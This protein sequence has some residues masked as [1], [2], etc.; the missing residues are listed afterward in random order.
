MN[1]V[2]FRL[3]MVQAK[4]FRK[5][6]SPRPACEDSQSSTR[7]SNAAEAT[8]KRHSDDEEEGENE[9]GNES[10][11]ANTSGHVSEVGL[12]RC[13]DIHL[14]RGAVSVLIGGD[15]FQE[16]ENVTQ[17]EL[18]KKMEKLLKQQN[19]YRDKVFNVTHKLRATNFGQDR[20]R[21]R[22]WV[23]PHLGGIYVEG[24]E[25]AEP[26]EMTWE[27]VEEK[28]EEG[29][30]K[31][32]AETRAEKE[33][34][35]KMEVEIKDEKVNGME[36]N[37]EEMVSAEEEK[38][39]EVNGCVD[40][41]V[42]GDELPVKQ[43]EGEV[44]D[45]DKMILEKL[46]N[47]IKE[48]EGDT[49]VNG[50]PEAI[51]PKKVQSAELVAKEAEFTTES[52]LKGAEH[53]VNGLSE[54]VKGMIKDEEVVK[55]EKGLVN[56]TAAKE[57]MEIKKEVVDAEEQKLRESKARFKDFLGETI[58]KAMTQNNK[59]DLTGSA[60]RSIDSILKSDPKKSDSVPASS[61]ASFFDAFISPSL[62]SST[63]VSSEQMLKNLADQVS[64]KT[65]S[66]SSSSHTTWFSLVPRTPC[67]KPQP[68]PPPV[69]DLDAP[70]S[71]SYSPMN[72]FPVLP[73][74]ALNRD[75]NCATPMSEIS[76]YIM[77]PSANASR[78][79]TPFQGPSRSASEASLAI[80]PALIATFCANAADGSLIN[81]LIK[82]QE[83]QHPEPQPIPIGRYLPVHARNPIA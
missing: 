17:E 59:S 48:D 44:L 23:L 5:I 21:R 28:K 20:Y 57:E 18:E 47:G 37:G 22:Y 19:A 45:S 77:T 31:D 27:E 25:S 68:P 14:S 55:G 42:V 61:S 60:F 11:V 71:R 66:S 15:L 81:P 67:N 75:S 58:T 74:P 43:T 62:S 82:L 24:L 76:S 79:S 35:E 56:G 51:S 70:F 16:D 78:C 65:A 73:S 83:A 63:A 3:R 34:E 26:E 64:M 7:P 6:H 69:P 72:P 13:L 38:K 2:L 1:L 36:K 53:I 40:D 52:E 8:P 49:K 9:S 10:D 41:K 80:N 29:E 54:D 30:K 33:P 50:M 46:S 39:V 32:K 12:M 4:K